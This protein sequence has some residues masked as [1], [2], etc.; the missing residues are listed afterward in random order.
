[1]LSLKTQYFRPREGGFRNK[2]GR[3]YNFMH[4]KNEKY[5]KIYTPMMIFTFEKHYF[6]VSWSL[7]HSVDTVQIG[8]KASPESMDLSRT[9]RH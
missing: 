5:Q 9:E 1:M 4:C 2:M 3:N 6:V 7:V 8:R